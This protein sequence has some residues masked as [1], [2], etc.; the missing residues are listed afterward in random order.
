MLHSKTISVPLFLTNRLKELN[1]F[2]VDFIFL[3]SDKRF[4]DSRRGFCQ[5]KNSFAATYSFE[6][7]LI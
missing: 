3:Q 4:H 2:I 6:D 7:L 5:S 1:C